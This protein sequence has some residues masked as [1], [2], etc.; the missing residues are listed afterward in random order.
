[1]SVHIWRFRLDFHTFT[2]RK[3]MPLVVD[4]LTRFLSGKADPDTHEIYRCGLIYIIT[5]T[6]LHSVFG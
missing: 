2:D 3:I 5:H 4:N 6:I 1:M